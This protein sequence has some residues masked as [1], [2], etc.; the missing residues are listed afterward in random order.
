MNATLVSHAPV[1]PGKPQIIVLDKQALLQQQVVEMFVSCSPW[2]WFN[3]PMFCDIKMTLISKDELTVSM[4]VHRHILAHILLR[5]DALGSVVKAAAI[6]ALHTLLKSLMVKISKST[7][8]LWVVRKKLVK[9]D[10]SKVLGI[11]KLS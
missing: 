4:N 11:L 8:R 1:L 10:V 5:C 7:W 3:D 2:N 6:T 9:E